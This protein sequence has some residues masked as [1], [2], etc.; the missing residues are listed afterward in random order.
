MDSD[1][2]T[3]RKTKQDKNKQTNRRKVTKQKTNKQNLTKQEKNACGTGRGDGA[4]KGK[5]V[6]YIERA[7]SQNLPKMTNFCH[8]IFFFFL[9]RGGNGSRVSE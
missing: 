1:G 5:C 8:D 6:P 2:D 9:T 3:R 7:K 4:A